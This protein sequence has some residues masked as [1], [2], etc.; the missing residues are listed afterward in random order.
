MT[1]SPLLNFQPINSVFLLASRFSI[2]NAIKSYILSG[3]QASN[4]SEIFLSS[5]AP[6]MPMASVI[7]VI[8]ARGLQAGIG[9]KM[10]L[11]APGYHNVVIYDGENNTVVIEQW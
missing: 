1:V 4:H 8:I 7:S 11:N 3:R 2:G 6:F 10:E 9:E 5:V